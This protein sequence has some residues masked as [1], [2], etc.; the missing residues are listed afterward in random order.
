[1]EVGLPLEEEDCSSCL[2]QVPAERKKRPE[3]VQELANCRRK[4][5]ADCKSKKPE[6]CKRKEQED[7]NGKELASSFAVELKDAPD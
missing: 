6:D 5:G 4:M 7:C 1:V 2:E 3:V